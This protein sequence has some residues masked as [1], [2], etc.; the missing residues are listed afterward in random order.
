MNKVLKVFGFGNDTQQWISSFYTNI[1]SIF[2]NFHKKRLLSRG[3]NLSLP[4][5]SIAE[6]LA[7]KITEDRN[8]KGIQ[9]YSEFKI[10]QF[11]NDTSFNLEGDIQSYENLFK[12]LTTSEKISG[13]KLNYG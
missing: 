6:I 2:R 12:T 4:L 5:C 10:I 3:S 7:K 8:I 9:I 11:A 13:L 1:K